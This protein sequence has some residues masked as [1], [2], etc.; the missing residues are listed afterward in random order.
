MAGWNLFSSDAHSEASKYGVFKKGR[1]GVDGGCLEKGWQGGIELKASKMRGS[2]WWKEPE[3]KCFRQKE[4]RVK[5]CPVKANVMHCW[6]NSIDQRV[7]SCALWFLNLELRSV[8]D[9][10]YWSF[11]CVLSALGKLYIFKV[12]EKQTFLNTQLGRKGQWQLLSVI[13][14]Q[15]TFSL[16]VSFLFCIFHLF[17]LKLF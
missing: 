16:C 1:S 14:K 9:V 5:R 3:E 12:K 6:R 10:K 11:L 4:P 8:L 13:G 15:V 7:C 17:L 2:Q